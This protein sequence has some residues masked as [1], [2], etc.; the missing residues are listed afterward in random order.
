MAEWAL[1]R[2]GYSLCGGCHVHD[3]RWRIEKWHNNATLMAASASHI[4][5]TQ[6]FQRSDYL[7]ICAG[8]PQIRFI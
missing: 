4:H 6:M 8:K 2:G 7:G 3:G 1:P 5:H